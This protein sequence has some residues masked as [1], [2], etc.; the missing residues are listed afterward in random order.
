[1]REI[2]GR[3]ALRVMCCCL[4]LQRTQ[5]YLGNSGAASLH[6]TIQVNSIQK[7]LKMS[8]SKIAW[9]ACIPSGAHAVV[10]HHERLLCFSYHG[11]LWDK[12]ASQVSAFSVIKMRTKEIVERLL[13]ETIHL[14]YKVHRL[15][16]FFQKKY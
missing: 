1:M 11:R 13:F 15:F 12:N 14:F 8:N 10:C 2:P 6:G 3:F 4:S 7:I 16:I 5:K 9:V